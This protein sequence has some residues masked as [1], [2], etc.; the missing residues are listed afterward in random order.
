MKFFLFILTIFIINCSGNKVT[1]YHG[2]KSLETKFDQIIINKSN[3]NDLFKII[4]SPS[5]ISEFNQNKWIY[6]E[7]LKTNQSVLKFGRQKIEKN[8][9][10][11]VKFNN[12]GILENK[13]LLDINDMNN[14]KY[15]KAQTE[16]D[17]TNSSVL[18]GVFS[19]LR[20]KINAPLKNKKNN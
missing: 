19:S 15:L 11:I 18:F 2:S 5:I 14:L 17:F 20:E 13:E 6:I 8:N 12:L 3:K 4:G 10:L 7:R 16:K 9:I 1:N